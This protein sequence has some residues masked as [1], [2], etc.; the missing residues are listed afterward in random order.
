[1]CRKKRLVPHIFHVE[2]LQHYLKQTIPPLTSEEY[3]FFE[4]GEIVKYYET[5]KNFENT[6]CEP[7][8]NE[9]GLLFHEF[10]MLLGRI[11]INKK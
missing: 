4:Q 5:D 11:A 6:S 8:E 1:M 9:P 7:L 3:N 10:I 2:D